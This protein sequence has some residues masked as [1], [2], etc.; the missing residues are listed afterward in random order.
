MV[1]AERVTATA[2]SA[3]RITQA[4]AGTFRVFERRA[5]ACAPAKGNEHA[6]RIKRVEAQQWYWE[7]LRWEIR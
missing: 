2:A 6:L 7:E 4:Y 1:V 3:F 5:T